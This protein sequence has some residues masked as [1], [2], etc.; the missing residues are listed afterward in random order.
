MSALLDQLAT[1]IQDLILTLGYPGV[2]LIMLV[3]N[4]FPPIPSELVMPFAGFTV[5]QGKLTFVGVWIAGTLGS[6][7]GA[8]VLYYIG[9]VLGD[10]VLRRLIRRY[11]KWLTVSEADYDR[12]LKVFA[13]YGDIV[14]FIGRVFPLIRSIISL[15]A[16][17]H[18]MPLPRFI[19]LTTLGS[20]IWSGLLAY[21]GLV[22]GD[23][24]ESVTTFIERYQE[25]TVIVVA[26]GALVVLLW[27]IT[28]RMRS[29]RQ[30]VVPD[31]E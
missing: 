17:A 7:L 14:V 21:G 27:L 15:P 26:G 6:V 11:G 28:S 31:V 18:H 4:V 29:R 3:E 23:N 13:K 10:T 5:A 24:W 9:M 22:L 16:G 2:T 25:I 12:A 19:L 1:F 20:A 8:V 30:P